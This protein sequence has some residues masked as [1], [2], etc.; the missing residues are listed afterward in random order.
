[1]PEIKWLD[2]LPADVE[3]GGSR[4]TQWSRLAAQLKE[5]PNHWAEVAVKPSRPGAVTLKNDIASGK[6]GKAFEPEGSF[7]AGIRAL[8]DGRFA[9]VAAYVGNGS[10]PTATTNGDGPA[11]EVADPDADFDPDTD[12][13]PE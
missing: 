4:L 1:M 3:V 2:E 8:P 12:D 6:K 11:A 10:A 9:V 7:E 13:A 5:D